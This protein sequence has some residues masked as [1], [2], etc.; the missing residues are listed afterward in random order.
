[1]KDHKIRRLRRYN[2]PVVTVVAVY[3]D[4][5]L[6]DLNSNFIE[7]ETG[8]MNVF[9]DGDKVRP[10]D[11]LGKGHTGLWDDDFE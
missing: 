3:G 2:K 6:A 11:A 7:A 1:M 10:E 8:G 4:C 9:P 5:L